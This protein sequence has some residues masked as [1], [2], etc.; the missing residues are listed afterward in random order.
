[1]LPPKNDKKSIPALMAVNQRRIIPNDEM[2]VQ[3]AF[4]Q[5]LMNDLTEVR[6]Q[7]AVAKNDLREANDQLDLYKSTCDRLSNEVA[8]LTKKYCEGTRENRS[9]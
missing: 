9:L 6:S 4:N 3:L 8:F 2:S 7:L 5:K 1:M